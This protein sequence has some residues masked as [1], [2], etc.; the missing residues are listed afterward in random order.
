[1]QLD[2]QSVE[3][4]PFQYVRMMV[5]PGNVGLPRLSM[6]RSVL[7]DLSR[8]VSRLSR[9]PVAVNRRHDVSDPTGSDTITIN[10]RSDRKKKIDPM[11]D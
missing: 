5:C 2:L 8:A 10:P 1:M 4:V 7:H 9:C 3:K 6:S 11:D